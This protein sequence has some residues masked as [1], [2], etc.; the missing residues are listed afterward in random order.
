MRQEVKLTKHNLIILLRFVL[1]CKLHTLTAQ[2][3]LSSYLLKHTF[4]K[5]PTA[6]SVCVHLDGL[7]AENTFQ[8]L[9]YS[10]E[11]CM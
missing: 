1:Q 2:T 5:M 10:V 7:N 4:S 9:L 11:L 6:P 8:C 3:L